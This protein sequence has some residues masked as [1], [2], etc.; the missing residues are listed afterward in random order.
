MEMH[1]FCV[2][3]LTMLSLLLSSSAT[4]ASVYCELRQYAGRQ[5]WCACEIVHIFATAGDV[6][7][8]ACP[9][10]WD[11]SRECERKR[12]YCEEVC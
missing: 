4:A 5:E 2:N 11:K 10:H 12:L 8:I 7:N 3:I 1:I 6:R 9:I